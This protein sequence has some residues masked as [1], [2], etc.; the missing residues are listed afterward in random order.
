MQASGMQVNPRI[1]I[2]DVICDP[3]KIAGSPVDLNLHIRGALMS[4]F[5]FNAKRPSSITPVQ[6][7]NEKK[8]VIRPGSIKNPV[9]ITVQTQE[10]YNTLTELCEKNQ[11]VC[12]I[13]IDEDKPE[14]I[15]QLD[16]L[17]N[18][19]ASVTAK[20]KIGRNNICICG[21]G[22]KYKKCCALS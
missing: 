8:R 20:Q 4:Q 16:I 11:W 10:R 22:K 7:Y 17:R 15:S 21:S 1:Y 3:D 12:N 19:P 5:P 6:A 2:K 18:K 13:S 14:D 9:A